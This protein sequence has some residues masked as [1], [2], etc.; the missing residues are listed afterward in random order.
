[1]VPADREDRGL[2]SK[3]PYEKPELTVYGPVVALTQNA[4]RGRS[5]NNGR[6][7]KT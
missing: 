6:G 2:A 3:K 4:G 1:V 5:D 7:G